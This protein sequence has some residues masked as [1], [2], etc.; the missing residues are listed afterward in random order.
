MPH[1]MLSQE[2][3]DQRA[4]QS[5]LDA[6]PTTG[7]KLDFLNRD[8]EPGEKASDAVDYEDIDDDDLA[9]DEDPAAPVASAAVNGAV[10]DESDGGL[11]DL[12]ELMRDE[13]FTQTEGA[14]VSGPDYDD[15]FG[16]MPTSV[17]HAP[18]TNGIITVESELDT[19]FEAGD[20]SQQLQSSGTDPTTS[21]SQKDTLAVPE[22]IFRN[23]NFGATDQPSLSLPP[24]PETSEEALAAMWPKF[25]RKEIPKWMELLPPKKARYTGKTPLK[26]PKPVQPTKINLDITAD[27]ERGFKLYG[28]AVSSKRDREVGAEQKGLILIQ[29]PDSEVSS[30]D[31]VAME[32]FSDGA[33]VGSITWNDLQIICADWDSKLAEEPSDDEAVELESAS[34]LDEDLFGDEG[35]DHTE[36]I[37]HERPRKRQKFSHP[38]KHLLPISNYALPSYDDPERTTAK[39]AKKV[40][41]D[42]NDPHLL[43]DI[44]EPHELIPEASRAGSTLKQNAGVTRDL[45][46]RYNIS[47][48][49][50]YDLLKE[51]HQSK[52]RSTLGNLTVEHSLPAIKLQ[53]PYYKV[54]LARQEARSFHRPAMSFL[55]NMAVR[56]SRLKSVK[57]KGLKGKGAQE[58][59]QLTK[60]LSLADNSNCLLF[61][62]SEE[63]PLMLSNFG[64]GS[65]LL[66]YYR[67]KNAEDSARPKLDVGETTVLMPQDK[68]PFS[69]FGNIE[70]GEVMPTLY[71][72]M[73]RAPVFR[74]EPSP[75]D[76]LVIRNTTGVEG[77]SWYMKNLENL[78]VVGQEFPSVDVP[79]PHSRKVTTAA[80]NRLKM[81]TYRKVKHNKTHR[82]PIDKVTDHFPGSSDMQNR[83]KMKEFMQFNR[84]SKE[85]EMRTGEPIPEEET[86]RRMV[87]PEDVCLLEAS[88][89]GLQHLQDAGYG[90]MAEAEEN[91]EGG[92][93]QSLE[94]QLAPWATTR[95]FLNATQGKAM[96]QLH[97]EGD[98]S[99]RGE[100]F[101]FIRTSMKGGF[102]AIGESVEDKIDA[103][104]LKEMGG[105]SYNVAKQQKAYEESIRRIWEAQKTSLSSKLDQTAAEDDVGDAPE[106]L[107]EE[108]RTPRSEVVTPAP[109]HRVDD[110]SASQFSKLSKL[111][112]LSQRGKLLRITRDI[113]KGSRV[114]KVTTEVR[115]PRVIREYL[116]RRHAIEAENLKLHEL[117]PTG[118]AEDDRRAQKRLEEEL[119][120]L[121]RNK[122]RRIARD[123]QK[124]LLPNDGSAT[125]PGSPSSP[126]TSNVKTTGTQ[127]KCAN[128]GQV[129]HIKT[130]KKCCD[131]SVSTQSALIYENRADDTFRPQALSD[132]ER[133]DEAGGRVQ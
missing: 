120:R 123:K 67:R 95:N 72:A 101:S 79:G 34:S 28:P 125:S 106:D 25:H 49:D 43:V 38:D 66:N 76:F 41:L 70:P 118:N 69:M 57:K 81:I 110:E 107:F 47:N 128:C 33:D 19:S 68:S 90:K 74:H 21:S 84:D 104:R 65:R 77:S 88:Q 109:H 87:K 105:H 36:V 85:W 63:Y 62:Y 40:T 93:T 20:S 51:N 121:E 11:E 131:P 27:P 59:F 130:N 3:L 22:T 96:L 53:Y 80:K 60:D 18:A 102:K 75:T 42:L 133:R 115:D 112:T 114:E 129:G 10:R 45:A 54:A 35:D 9:D 92:E 127:R 119:A 24:P 1:S 61:E 103:K 122:E 94:Q 113:K 29:D 132:A 15:L 50:A 4:I 124:G 5:V 108:G 13:S 46:Q 52:V 78:F 7:P 44:R 86:V 91:D 126:S 55:P 8:L 98:P 56:F 97:G 99:G 83:Q 111:S 12:D 16:D 17:D 48:D 89:V 117:R 23:V 116:K 71:N 2:E 73:F 82:V 37:V 58:T 30:D 100:A 14:D 32:D 39:L 26:P 64:M 31:D 6:D